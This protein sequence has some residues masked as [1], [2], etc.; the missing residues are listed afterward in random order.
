MRKKNKRL[1]NRKI[2]L[3]LIV[4]SI[5]FILFAKLIYVQIFLHSKVNNVVEKMVKRENIEI[6]KRGNIL[7]SHGRVLATSIKKYVVFIDPKMVRDFNRI[8]SVLSK[9]KIEIKEKS[10]EDFRNTSYVPIIFNVDANVVNKIKNEKLSGIGFKSKYIRQYP[11]GRFLTHVLGIVDYDGNGLEGI[12][13]IC[14]KFLSGDPIV[15]KMKRDGLGHVIQDKFVDKSKMCGQDVILSIDRTIQFI[16]E[17]EL[18][19]V[20]EKYKARKAICIVQNPK[21]GDI[22]AMVSLPDFDP[23]YKIKNI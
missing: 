14:N 2:I 4:L 11:E 15:T 12:E 20:F 16:A 23:S 9:N 3:M 21:T 8:K 7:D 6:P 18:R 19:K 22:L 5:F 17:Q 1:I 10:L 13:K